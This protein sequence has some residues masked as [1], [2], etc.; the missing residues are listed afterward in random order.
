MYLLIHQCFKS[1]LKQT[2]CVYL[3]VPRNKTIIKP[4]AKCVKVASFSPGVV[5]SRFSCQLSL[6]FGFGISPWPR[7]L[8]TVHTKK[9]GIS[10]EVYRYTSFTPSSLEHCSSP[11]GNLGK[12]RLQGE[13]SDPVVF[14]PLVWTWD[15]NPYDTSFATFLKFCT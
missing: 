7:F 6:L 2:F 9:E 4:T 15:L 11:A 8:G 12:K 10:I 3:S 1:L 13:G 5:I 14:Q